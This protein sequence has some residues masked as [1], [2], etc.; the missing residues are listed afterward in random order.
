MMVDILVAMVLL[1]ILLLGSVKAMGYMNSSH[2]INELRYLALNKIDSEMARLVMTY[3]NKSPLA[4]YVELSSSTISSYKSNPIGEDYGLKVIPDGKDLI[5]IKNTTGA[6]N[7]VD[8][9]D[10]VGYLSW[11]ENVNAKDA[12]LSLNIEYPY[13]YKSDDTIEQVWDFTESVNLQTS[14]KVQ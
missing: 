10:I 8:A 12:N 7:E 4:T 13:R 11:S 2:Q 3:E 1:A 9:N 6:F 14:T 5:E